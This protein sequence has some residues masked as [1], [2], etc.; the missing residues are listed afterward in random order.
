MA[1]SLVAVQLALRGKDK[2]LGSSVA[3]K[4]YQVIKK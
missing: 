4:S 2:M 3:H 1:C